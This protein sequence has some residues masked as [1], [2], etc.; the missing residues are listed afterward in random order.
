MKFLLHTQI[1]IEKIAK[2]ELFSKFKSLF[3]LDFIG[4]VPHKNGIILIDWR[5]DFINFHFNKLGSVEDVFL[6]LNY[7]GD[8]SPNID[9]YGIK[10]YV[11]INNL[12]EIISSYLKINK[13]RDKFLT[14]R[15]VVRK[16]SPH[17]FR[18]VDLQNRIQN[19]LSKVKNI[20]IVQEEGHKE[21]WVTLVKNRLIIGLRLTDKN[22][23]HRLYKQ[24]GVPGSLRPTVAFSMA[25]V[26]NVLRNHVIWD[27]FCGA[28]TICCELLENFRFKKLICSDISE[29]AVNITKTNI[30]NCKN[31]DRF[32]S[33]LSIKQKDF[34]ASKDYADMI[35]TNLPF[36]KKYLVNHSEFIPNFIDKINKIPNLK[37]LTIIYPDKLK[38]DGWQL[39][40]KYKLKILGFDCY[41]QVHKKLT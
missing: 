26:S 9:L 19:I 31:Y 25:F 8:I 21:I 5:S 15:L 40:K 11:D 3:S 10:R 34:F 1:G 12:S 39:I 20:R 6:I 17:K 30:Q 7:A 29:D 13:F 38:I 4:Y 14:C 22:M 16:K 41:M 18:R 2:I 37:K 33:K 27:P 23:R 24:V 35:I 36:G 32:K 28:G